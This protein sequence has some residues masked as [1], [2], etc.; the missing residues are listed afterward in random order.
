MPEW[1]GKI[2]VHFWGAEVEQWEFYD[3]GEY[4]IPP[5]ADVNY[6]IFPGALP[7]KA[8]FLDCY[9]EDENTGEIITCAFKQSF[10]CEI[11]GMKVTFPGGISPFHWE[12]PG[13]K[14]HILANG[15]NGFRDF[16]FNFSRI[17][18][19]VKS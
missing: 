15:S 14:L 5:N 6:V 13:W 16:A 11:P 9:M 10:S 18:K 19:G 17:K 12:L 7:G 8:P 3:D 2:V 4:S 1:N